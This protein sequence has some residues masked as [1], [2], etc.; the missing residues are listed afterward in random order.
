MPLSDMEAYERETQ[1]V[2]GRFLRHELSFPECIAALDATLADFMPRM[3]GEQIARVRVVML[4]N[5]EIVVKEMERRGQ[6][7]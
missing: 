5:N 3:T 7:G 2:I 4:A 6:T 1:A